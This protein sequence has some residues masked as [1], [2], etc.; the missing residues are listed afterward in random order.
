[1]ITF[2]K[3]MLRQD[4]FDSGVSNCRWDPAVVE[5]GSEV[6]K[7]LFG[8]IY[9]TINSISKAAYISQGRDVGPQIRAAVSSSRL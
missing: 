2:K 5:H 4:N 7:V 6:Q 9:Q 3:A 1:M 8:A